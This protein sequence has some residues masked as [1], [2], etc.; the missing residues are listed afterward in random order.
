MYMVKS[1][2]K[3]NHIFDIVQNPLEMDTYLK[4]HEN[5]KDTCRS[6]H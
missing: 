3:Y 5:R 4:M 2:G 6:H 1:L